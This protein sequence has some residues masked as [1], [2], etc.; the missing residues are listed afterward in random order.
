M[1]DQILT[2]EV[3]KVGHRRDI[4]EGGWTMHMIAISEAEAKLTELARIADNEPV[5]LLRHSKP[6][7]VLVSPERYEDLMERLED[8]ED[9]VA[10]LEHRLNPQESISLDQVRAGLAGVDDPAVGA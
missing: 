5:Y 10:L 2:V 1:E 9:R 4:Y 7:G 6:A 8:A 3:V